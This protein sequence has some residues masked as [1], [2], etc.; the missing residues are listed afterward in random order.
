MKFRRKKRRTPYRYQR[1]RTRRRNFAPLITFIIAFSLFVFLS[2]K[3]IKVIFSGVRSESVASE[4]QV[5]KGRTEFYF[6]EKEEWTPAYSELKFLEGDSIRT[7]SN[8]QASLEFF[9]G[10][11]VF[12]DENTEINLKELSEKSSGQKNTVIHLKQ[13]QIWVKVS[14][15]DFD[16]EKD[17]KFQVLT[18]R[19]KAHVRGTIFDL[20]TSTDQDVIRLIKG[21][22]DVD[23]LGEKEDEV[24][25]NIKVEV[26]QKLVV[27]P[28]NME[29]IQAGQDVKEIID[30]EFIESEWHL[31]N[32]EQ[33]FPQEAAQ[34]RRRID[35]TTP[36]EQPKLE[37]TPNQ[38][39]EGIEAPVILEPASGT[40]VVASADSVKIEGTAPSDA[41]QIV[42]NGYTLSRFQPGDRKWVYFA[43][44]KFGTLLPG[45]NNY[46]IIA[47]S[48]EGQKSAPAKLA[49]T[50]QGTTTPT[51][52]E[53]SVAP[54]TAATIDDFK[55]PVITSPPILNPGE[56]YQTS[57]P[58]VTIKGIVDPK[59][60]AVEVNGFRLQKFVPGK[61]E[62][63]YVANS[64]VASPNFKT[65]ENIF[66]I[67]AF[68]PDNKKA[69]TTLKIL[70]NPVTVTP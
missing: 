62:F 59:T 19:V 35:I 65:G 53:A 26:G 29:N 16:T 69:S 20:T 52:T 27:S 47:V 2:I 45:E 28:V 5:I 13:G 7:T 25:Q 3:L 6:P 55:S 1:R 17:S 24:L 38:S 36:Q 49:I 51:N 42:V 14:E 67:V 22:V 50:Y 31:Q 23:V 39:G 40:T 56:P 70:Y 21:N 64:Q 41:M 58:A 18:N 9:G 46:E 60:N 37:E 63:Q 12:L 33:F 8:S 66:E 10:T 34:I 11:L 30:T 68:G 32:L 43:S 44:T 4:I 48:R 61:T 54:I 57:A 15:D